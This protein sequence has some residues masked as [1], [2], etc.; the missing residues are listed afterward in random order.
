MEQV[1]AARV[2]AGHDL[3]LRRGVRDGRL[4]AAGDLER[5]H[6]TVHQGRLA[7]R[8]ALGVEALLARVEHDGARDVR[9]RDGG[10]E[11]G[12]DGGERR[13]G[14]RG[15]Q[16]VARAR[17]RDSPADAGPAAAD[18]PPRGA[19]TVSRICMAV[20]N[21]FCAGCPAGVPPVIAPTRQVGTD[22]RAPAPTAPC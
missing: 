4:V 21:P 7:E 18:C 14:R 6:G 19:R 10:R 3:E 5:E 1:H 22:H 17:G 9:A 12:G 15:D 16:H 20:S 2:G 8:A 11:V 13:P